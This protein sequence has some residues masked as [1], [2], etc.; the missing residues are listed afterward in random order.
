LTEN[1]AEIRRRNARAELIEQY[2]SRILSS[3]LDEVPTSTSSTSVPTLMRRR[4]NRNESGVSHSSSHSHSPIL[5][6][7]P[8]Q[9]RSPSPPILP[10]SL[11]EVLDSV[12]RETQNQDSMEEPSR[13][14]SNSDRR[15]YASTRNESSSGTLGRGDQ[16]NDMNVDSRLDSRARLNVLD[17]RRRRVERILRENSSSRSDFPR[18]HSHS[19][20]WSHSN[21]TRARP[22]EEPDGFFD[23]QSSTISDI[24]RT[25]TGNGDLDIPGIET[26]RRTS[27]DT[28]ASS[29]SSPNDNRNPWRSGPDFTD[30]ATS[31]APRHHRSAS[32]PPPSIPP[33]DFGD[34]SMLIPI[35]LPEFRPNQETPGFVHEERAN[36]RPSIP[37]SSVS[38]RPNHPSLTTRHPSGSSHSSNPSTHSRT[39]STRG[40]VDVDSFAGPFRTTVQRMVDQGRLRSSRPQIPLIPPLTFDDDFE[41]F[42]ELP[43]P[44]RA[45]DFLE[46][47]VSLVTLPN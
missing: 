12:D 29:L 1:A 25:I 46:T 3:G 37:T 30:F 26:E 35:D 24:V 9:F 43:R 23:S 5:P 33:P 36:E 10:Q 40:V 6:P 17:E 13:Y 4:S 2:S 14:L 38:S 11:M 31:A 15:P 20:S 28:G 19:S 47:R 34:P 18:A 7:L 8:H 39:S 21:G 16:G 41:S 27:E 32:N 42:G 44:S 22:R 45:P